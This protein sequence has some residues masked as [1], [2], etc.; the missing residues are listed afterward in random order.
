MCMDEEKSTIPFVCR[1]PAVVA[2]SHQI[3]ETLSRRYERTAG[4]FPAH[5]GHANDGMMC[6]AGEILVNGY[7]VV[8]EPGTE[9]NIELNS[10]PESGHIYIRHWERFLIASW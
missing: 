6:A 10:T 4:G 2:T 3:C 5:A 1:S 7:L 8:A 9:P